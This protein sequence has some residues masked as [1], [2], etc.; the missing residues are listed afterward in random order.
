MPTNLLKACFALLFILIINTVCQQQATAQNNNGQIDNINELFTKTTIMLPMQD[1]VRLATD[2]FLPVLSDDLGYVATLPFLGTDTVQLLKKGT[3]YMQYTAQT[4][5]LQLPAILTRTPYGKDLNDLGALPV[6]LGYASIVQDTRGRF[7]SEGTYIP[8]YHDGWDKRPYYSFGSPLDASAGNRANNDQD[9]YQTIQ[10]LI[11]NVYRDT[12]SIATLSGTELL[13]NGNLSVFGAS[14]L[15]NAAYSAA[16]A[17]PIDPNAAGLKALL[18]I[19]ASGEFYNT[20]GYH[21]GVF[22]ERLIMGW[23]TGT[24]GPLVTSPLDNDIDNTI[25]SVQDYG[26]ATSQQVYNTAYNSWTEMNN[27]S[28]PDSRFRKGL[29][30][31][32][33][34]VDAAGQGD[35]TGNFSRYEN[36]E[37]PMYHLTGWWDIFI[38]GQIETFQQA[39]KHLSP[40]NRSRQKLVIGP[41]TH[42]TIGQTEVGDMTGPTAYPA[43]VQD[44]LGIAISDLSLTG[45]SLNQVFNSELLQW[46]RAYLGSPEI[47]L[48]ANDWQSFGTAEVRVPAQDYIISYEDF[49]NF[50]S[51]SGGLLG[52]P[53]EVRLA[54]NLPPIASTIDVPASGISITGDTALINIEPLPDF[55]DRNPQGVPAVRLYVTGP[56]NDGTS[57][58]NDAG[59]YWLSADTFPLPGTTTAKLYFDSNNK[60]SATAPAT[61]AN[62][63]YIHNPDNPVATVGGN[64]MLISRNGRRSQGQMNM[65]DPDW[66]SITMNRSDVITFET[67]SLTDT[68]SVIGYPEMTLYASSLPAGATAGDPTDTDFMIRIT[69]VYPNGREM[70]VTEGTVNARAREYAKSLAKG[71]ENV[72]APFS[73][74]DAGQM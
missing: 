70:L 65:A 9:G 56:V 52:L 6:L 63:N 13:L 59:N 72:N 11:N 73:N 44:V 34:P 15:G 23:L 47:K 2:V 64:N 39:R 36:M 38:N 12:N 60:L 4:N 71:N 62:Y 29:D 50:I 53:V 8:M 40:E 74:I 49:I 16:A 5:P 18:P 54:P 41:W 33:A 48:P 19:V 45:T 58:N 3:Q 69:D 28:Y 10:A 37:V 14:A 25:H 1:S 24:I 26:F 68:L 35:S 51:G 17:Q 66:A 21:N 57:L 42:Q 20:A 61:V 7:A 27:A 67:D 31:S 32:K 43:Q 46:F 22:R 55:D 30:V